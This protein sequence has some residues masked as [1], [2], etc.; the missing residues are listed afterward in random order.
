MANI[1]AA[2]T[3]ELNCT[4]PKCNEYVD[5]LDYVDFWDGRRLDIAESGTERSCDIEVICPKCDHEFT[6]DCEY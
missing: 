2:W 6:V 4:C 1:T 5:L 3:V